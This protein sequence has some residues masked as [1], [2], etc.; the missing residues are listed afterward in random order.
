MSLHVFMVQNGWEE[1]ANLVVPYWQEYCQK[2]GYTFHL[3]Q[4]ILPEYSNV[5]SSFSKTAQVLAYYK[6]EMP[7]ALWV[8]DMDMLITN[9][10][11]AAQNYISAKHAIT[12]TN[13][14]NGL[15]S[16][17]YFLNGFWTTK[18]ELWLKSVLSLRFQT[19]SEQHSMWWLEEAYREDTFYFPHPSFNSIPY[20]KYSYGQQQ[21]DQGQWNEGQLLCHLPGM[22]NEQR[23]EIF[24]QIIPLIVK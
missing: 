20:H 13:D 6:K 14:I 1:L 15:N 9:F 16:G 8:V 22:T 3:E 11:I 17:S 23:I 18:C 10:G 24:N 21:W 19:T 5:H 2:W 12:I 7:Q 4:G